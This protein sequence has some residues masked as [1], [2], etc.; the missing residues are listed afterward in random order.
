MN[1]QR[2][3]AVVIAAVFLYL[4]ARPGLT[5]EGNSAVKEILENPDLQEMVTK[6]KNDPEAAAKAI[7]RNP[8][9]LAR[10]AAAIFGE[11]QQRKEKKENVPPAT[12]STR[13]QSD[14]AL[15]QMRKI[16]APSTSSENPQPPPTRATRTETV[17]SVRE[18]AAE[19]ARKMRFNS[20]KLKEA[21]GDLL[22]G[23]TPPPILDPIDPPTAPLPSGLPK[24]EP[25]P[26]S[27]LSPG[28][29]PPPVRTAGSAPAPLR[30][31][32]PTT[33]QIPDSPELSAGA[34]PEPEAHPRYD[35]PKRFMP[36]VPQSKK[37]AGAD[38][39]VIT[40]NDSEMDNKNGILTFTNDV[41]V[42]MENM[43]LTCDK[44]VVHLD[45]K[46][47]MERSVATGGLV[48]IEQIGA[49]GKLRLAK[50][51]RAEHIAAT[52]TNILTGGPPYL[53]DGD[54]YVVT[55]S[56]DSKIILGGDGKYKV[57]SP[58]RQGRSVIVVPI[59]NGKK[60]QGDFGIDSKLKKIAQ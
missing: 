51:R 34:V 46:N 45:D 15:E 21:A 48:K 56:E 40:C 25:A 13:S 14:K 28:L 42:E 32:E 50:C 43:K 16:F 7:Q 17:E 20:S 57:H 35:K 19:A 8:G 22:E 59:S 30:N 47:E 26:S 4:P 60:L 5:Q 23:K 44:L 33:P 31:F 53:Q 41:V 11:Q 27:S 10:N 9:E 58:K 39:M 37:N 52:E 36:A 49:D 1:T 55:D 24:T 38:T 29:P 18:S 54:R 12:R 6:A 3:T 2:F